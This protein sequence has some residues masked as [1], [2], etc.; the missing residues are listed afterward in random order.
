LYDATNEIN[1]VNELNGKEREQIVKKKWCGG[2]VE[3][4]AL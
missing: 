2:K 1:K 3:M 4:D